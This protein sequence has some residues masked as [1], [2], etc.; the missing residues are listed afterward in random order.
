MAALSLATESAEPTQV[1]AFS[2]ATAATAQQGT[3]V[4]QQ[5][6]DLVEPTLVTESAEPMQALMGPM[7]VTVTP[8][9]IT[10]KNPLQRALLI[11]PH[12]P[13]GAFLFSFKIRS[14][15]QL[16]SNN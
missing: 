6:M 7:P 5:V 8:Q 13:C 2:L 10:L 9:V 4:T 14:L 16:R 3:Q 12:D 11:A 1:T 15:S